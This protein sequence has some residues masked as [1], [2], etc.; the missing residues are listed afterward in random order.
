MIWKLLLKQGVCKLFIYSV[1][2]IMNPSKTEIKDIDNHT[3][4][5]VVDMASISNDVYIETKIDKLLGT[6]HK[7]NVPT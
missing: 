6:L 7:V 3:I 5:S 2:C 1:L 4:I